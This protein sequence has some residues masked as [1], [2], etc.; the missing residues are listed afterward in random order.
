MKIYMHRDCSKSLRTTLGTIIHEYAHAD[1][2]RDFGLTLTDY[3]GHL[4]EIMCQHAPS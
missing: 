2:I 3:L 4:A 1:V